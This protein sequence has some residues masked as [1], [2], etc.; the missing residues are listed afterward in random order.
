MAGDFVN[1]NEVGALT[2]SGQGYE[3]TAEQAPPYR[4]VYGPYPV[5][6]DC[7]LDLISP[8]DEAV[9]ALTGRYAFVYEFR[10]D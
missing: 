2:R 3:G 9:M 4:W 10:R 1:L 5:H 7:R 6:E 8:Q